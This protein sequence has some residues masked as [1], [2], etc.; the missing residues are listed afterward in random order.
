MEPGLKTVITDT[1]LRPS[2]S[3]VLAALSLRTFASA[4]I[5]LDPSW[6]PARENNWRNGGR[7]C[8]GKEFDNARHE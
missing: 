4:H 5:V 1:I 3:V 8:A 2:T 7:A 6:S